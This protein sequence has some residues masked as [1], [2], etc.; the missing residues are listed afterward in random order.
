MVDLMV[1]LYVYIQVM[2]AKEKDHCSIERALSLV[3]ESFEILESIGIS[4]GFS[5]F[6]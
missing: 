1:T 5:V 2:V 4:D 6:G 3:F